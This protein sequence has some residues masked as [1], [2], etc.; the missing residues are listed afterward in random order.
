MT[1][2]IELKYAINTTLTTLDVTYNPNKHNWQKKNLQ[3]NIATSK[4]KHQIQI[5]FEMQRWEYWARQFTVFTCKFPCEILRVESSHFNMNLHNW[6]IFK[7]LDCAPEMS[8]NNSKAPCTLSPKLSYG[9]FHIHHLFLIKY[10]LL[11]LKHRKSNLTGIFL[12]LSEAVCKH[13]WHKVRWYLFF[14]VQHYV[15]FIFLRTTLCGIYFLTYNIMWYLFFYVQKF[16]MRISDSCELNNNN[17]KC[18]KK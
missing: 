18:N 16:W 11:M 13:D 4:K 12:W 1:R 15:V 8:P 6:F 5:K 3:R 7:W 14:N 17:N 10:F 9:F 2:L